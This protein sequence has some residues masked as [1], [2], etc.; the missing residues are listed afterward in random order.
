MS[1][2]FFLQTASQVL[3]DLLTSKFKSVLRNEWQQLRESL[4]QERFYRK[5]LEKFLEY[6][7]SIPE[8]THDLPFTGTLSV[9]DYVLWPV[10]EV[11]PWQ[12]SDEEEWRSQ[13]VP[14]RELLSGIPSA[15][16]FAIEGEA[17]VGKTTLAHTLVHHAAR[18]SLKKSTG[19]KSEIAPIFFPLYFDADDLVQLAEPGTPGLQ[20]DSEATRA[21]LRALGPKPSHHS[22]WALLVV[23]D[24]LDE[25]EDHLRQKALRQLAPLYREDGN[26]RYL[27]LG[28]PNS[29]RGIPWV[30]E[31][32]G[33]MR[34]LLRPWGAAEVRAY[35][36]KWVAAL[37]TDTPARFIKE[38][39]HRLVEYVHERIGL[40]APV[41][42]VRMILGLYLNLVSKQVGE[43]LEHLPA[44][45]TELYQSYLKLLLSRR[46][47]AKDLKLRAD[48]PPEGFREWLG[49]L[50]LFLKLNP[51]ERR[52][53]RATC[54]ATHLPDLSKARIKGQPCKL[55]N[56]EKAALW[57]EKRRLCQLGHESLHEFLAAEALARLYEGDPAAFW[58]DW[59]HPRIFDP[60][61]QQTL[62]FAL[63]WLPESEQKELLTKLLSLGECDPISQATGRHVELVARAWGVGAFYEKVLWDQWQKHKPTLKQYLEIITNAHIRDK[64]VAKLKYLASNAHE[65][66]T[67]IIAAKALAKFDFQIAIQILKKE[68][69]E[70]KEEILKLW[71][72]EFLEKLDVKSAVS[73]YKELIYYATNIDIWFWA[74][75]GFQRLD[76]TRAI[77]AFNQMAAGG[78]GELLRLQAAKA[79]GELDPES[80]APILEEL[81]TSAQ[82][83]DVRFEAAEALGELGAPP[84][85][86][87]EL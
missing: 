72:T 65:G 67:R 86:C 10:L 55:Q 3:L 85:G 58:R 76:P 23:V 78:E 26:H 38:E 28:R 16:V 24:G 81:A 14:A 87:E 39:A 32:Q 49:C 82:N 68:A 6:Y 51:Q 57:W 56:E 34:L 27:L 21:L 80:A 8:L 17:G 15:H 84:I 54:S 46:E 73:F 64:A 37:K 1:A 52:V 66:I 75:K 83:E 50:E 48:T 47:E 36:E 2:E 79:L 12:E 30:R 25:I 13:A 33:T 69:A 42:M 77:L 70:A 63:T 35:F 43:P 59:L 7:G 44:T 31:E 45:R 61:W 4:D 40:P 5:Y 20:V 53:A 74:A 11:E 19:E 18:E 22:A 41:L 62:L 9:E 71:A 29:V 60:Y